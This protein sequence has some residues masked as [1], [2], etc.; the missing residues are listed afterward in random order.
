MKNDLLIAGIILVFGAAYLAGAFAINEPNTS[1]SAVGPRF[2]P[3]LIGVGMLIS[4]AWLGAQTWRKQ[5]AG[6][7]FADLEEMDWRTW[8]AAALTLL[9][10]IYALVPLGYLIA[11][12]AFLF[13]EARIFGSHA[14]LRD[15]IV[16]VAIALL[17][18]GFF[19]GLL[20]IGLPTGLLG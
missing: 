15:A 12:T 18:Y 6:G 3:I 13:V 2:F 9:I 20:K 17:V 14:W 4:G 16:S 11:T 1:Y 7:T 10:Y 8:G 19:N 5:R